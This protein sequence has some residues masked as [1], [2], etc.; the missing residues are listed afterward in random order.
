[1]YKYDLKIDFGGGGGG[2]GAYLQL[3]WNFG[4]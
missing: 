1:M 4:L 2:G 3:V